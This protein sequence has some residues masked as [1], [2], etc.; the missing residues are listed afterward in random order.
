MIE[1]IATRR[2]D[3]ARLGRATAREMSRPGRVPT[4]WAYGLPN[5]PNRWGDGLRD[6]PTAGPLHAHETQIM[7]EACLAELGDR[8][9]RFPKLVDLLRQ[10]AQEADA[11][12]TDEAA[13]RWLERTPPR[14]QVGI[15]A[16][17]ALAVTGNGAQRAQAAAAQ[18]CAAER[19][20]RRRWQP[21]INA[22]RSA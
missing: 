5:V 13:R 2:L 19:A 22:A 11:R 3:C 1:G 6:V 12:I 17:Q 16:R 4:A 10:V 18:A 15:S 21:E 9:P 20:Q 7:L 8:Q 14:T